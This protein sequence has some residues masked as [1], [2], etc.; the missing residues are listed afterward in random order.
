[1]KYTTEQSEWL[2]NNYGNVS[3]Y[4]ELV[5]LFNERFNTNR[6]LGQISDKCNKQLKLKGMPSQTRYGNKVK[7]QL[8]VGSIRISIRQGHRTT[9]IKVMEDTNSHISGYVEPY[10]M[11]LQKKIYQDHY[12]EIEK[13]KMVIFLDGNTENFD[14]NNLYCIDRKISAI[15]SKNRWWTNSIEHTLTAIKWCELWYAM[16]G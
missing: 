15:M 4:M 16:K 9:Y 6:S 1:M 14:I 8:P 12:G 10:W 13:G 3:S 5:T 2:K 7:E 11:P